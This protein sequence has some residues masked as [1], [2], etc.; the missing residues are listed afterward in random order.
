MYNYKDIKR[1]HLEITSKC[2]ARCPMCARRMQGG[3][4]LPW[5]VLNEI[6]LE[7]FKS[8]FPVEFLKQL[9]SFYMCGNLGDPII[10]K[11]TIPIFRYIR[12]TNP[13]IKLQMHTNG[14]AR[15]SQF[16]MDLTELKVTVV[17]GIDGLS[18]T[19][20]RYRIN[21][22]FDKILENAKVFIESG[23]A[24][25][26]DMLV[27]D[28]NKH[29]IEECRILAK[30]LGFESFQSKNSSRFKDEK[31]HV[32]DDS[33]KTIDILYPTDRSKSFIKRIENS[34]N[35]RSPIITCKAKEYN[36][37]YISANGNVSPCCWL[38]IEW[39]PPVNP[40]R[41]DYMDKLGIFPNLNNQTLIDIFNSEFFNKIKKT[42]DSNC[43][44]TCKKQCGSFNKSEV[45]FES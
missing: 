17:F 43:L 18:D 7:Q 24:A 13:K 8:W 35:D 11:D 19:H 39:L 29:Q 26:W 42:W 15:D 14:S 40:E 44:A 20:S 38:D 21:T 34:Q 6:F 28:Y 30:D 10:A 4:M 27:F 23:G 33:G 16:W 25:R 3:P 41:I 2:Q 5:V 37:L 45:Q 9:E 36:E 32:L 22:D 31:F 12:E 1:I